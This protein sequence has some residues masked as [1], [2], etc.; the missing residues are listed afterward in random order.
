MK[1]KELVN[2]LEENT[3]YQ[4]EAHGSNIILQD[5]LS[6]YQIILDKK[7]GINHNTELFNDYEVINII[8]SHRGL[9]RIQIK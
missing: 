2:L 8:G 1:V 6:K 9:L 4:I 3:F 7:A 5:K